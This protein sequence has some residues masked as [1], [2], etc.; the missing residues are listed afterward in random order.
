M[1][2][3]THETHT[4]HTQVGRDSPSDFF[5]MLCTRHSL[6]FYDLFEKHHH[7]RA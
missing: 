6:E 2:A 3:F 7:V 1:A 4:T 5:R